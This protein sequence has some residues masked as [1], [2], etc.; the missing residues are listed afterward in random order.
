MKSYLKLL[1]N[2]LICLL[3]VG[4]IC[5]CVRKEYESQNEHIIMH[6]YTHDTISK[7]TSILFKKIKLY[8]KILYLYSL[9]GHILPITVLKYTMIDSI[10]PFSDPQGVEIS[11][12]DFD[13]NGKEYQ[14]Q[15]YLFDDKNSND[16]ENYIYFNNSYGVLIVY[17]A[18]WE[19]IRT[20]YEYD[21]V[22]VELIDM[23][24]SDTTGFW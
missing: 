6:S 5:S 23:I 9:D 2:I 13:F 11:K 12:K 3:F 18:G 14:I 7:N 17:D 1:R 15:K 22:T 8:D 20:S 24:C 21:T 19:N 4:F 10:L 16:E